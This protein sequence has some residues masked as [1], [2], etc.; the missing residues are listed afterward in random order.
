MKPIPRKLLRAARLLG[1][2]TTLSLINAAPAQTAPVA[3]ATP[4]TAAPSSTSA[5]P[6]TATSSE[7]EDVV[8]LSPFIVRSDDND[9]YFSNS[10]TAGTRTRTELVNLP[11]SMQVLT[12]EFLK[13]IGA[14]DLIDAVSYASGVSLSAGQSTN[15]GD[16]TSFTLRGQTGFVPMRNGFRRL[17]L[18]GSANI[19]RVEVLKGPSSML[20]GQLNPGGSVN[21]VTKRPKPTQNF[22]NYQLQ[23]GSYDFYRAV[24]DVN[25]PLV[26][27]KLALRLVTSYEDSNSIVDRFSNQVTLI[28]PS[29]TWWIRPGTSLTVEYEESKRLTNGF[30]PRLPFNARVD[31]EDR[32]G[33]VTRSFN[34]AAPGDFNDTEM[35]VMTAEF[36][37]RF[38]SYLTLRANVT[39]GTWYENIRANGQNVTLSGAAFDTLP[40]RGITHRKR[41]SDDFWRQG[42]LVNNFSIAGIDVQNIVGYQYET[43]KFYQDYTG[44][45]VPASPLTQWN[46]FNPATWVVTELTEAQTVGSASDGFTATNTTRSLYVTNQLS[47]LDG[48]LRT[49]AG[50]R[51]DDFFVNDFTPSTGARNRSAAEPATIPQ[52]G[53]VYKFT[54]KFSV[55][56]NYSESFLPVFSSGRRP[57]GTQFSPSPQSGKGYDVGLRA[58]FFENKVAAAVSVFQVDNTDIVRFLQAVTITRPDGLLETFSPIEQSGTDRSE[59]IEFDLRLKPR[60]GTQIIA[61]YAYTDAWVLSDTSNNTR[62]TLADGSIFYTRTGHRLANA[63]EHTASLWGRHDFGRIGKLASFYVMGGAR[64]AT[65]RE[66]T[67]TYVVV[68]GVASKP[69]NMDGYLLFDAGFGGRFKLLGRDVNAT[70]NVKNVTDETWLAN[71][72]RYGEPRTFLFSFS[73]KF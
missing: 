26:P 1:A 70:L 47:M 48:K 17:R 41:G 21:Y 18:V 15:E 66:Q 62:V 8:T 29:L 52:V 51:R 37:H 57:D 42:E 20:Y 50:F 58:N 4:A 9:G 5:G 61:T 43:L 73:G 53:V 71:R 19:D 33:A 10:A 68:A 13:D 69:W 32:P 59:G 39:S 56:A 40:R 35:G 49:L 23:A 36:I 64:F 25:T 45:Q 2:V 67:E 46:I 7:D 54:P 63:P 12:E 60:K 31:Y 27:N 24:L 55:Y 72:F 14:I 11:I 22:L 38:T 44:V 3:P 34:T 30:S 65:D 16:N 28:N 6:D